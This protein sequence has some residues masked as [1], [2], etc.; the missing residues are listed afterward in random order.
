MNA[1]KLY[2]RQDIGEGNPLVLLHGMFGDGSQWSTIS[3][4]LSK[5]YR[6][7]VVDLLGHGRSPR[8]K[9]AIYTDKEHV[10]AL[11]NTLKSL[12][13]TK[14]ATVVGYSM[15]G[16][17]ALAYSSSYPESVIQL[18]LISTPF[19][20]K[21]E[22]MISNKYAGSIMFTKISTGVLGAI[23]KVMRPDSVGGRFADIGNKSAK[24]HAMIGAN[25]NVLDADIIRLNIQNLVTEFDFIG[26]LK[27]LQ[28]PLTFFA[29]KKDVFVVQPQ[30]NALRQFQPYMD[31]QRLEVIKIDHM[32]VQNLP[33]EISGL[34]KKNLVNALHIE[35]DEGK[36]PPLLL[37]HGIEGSSTYWRH[38]IKPLS[39]H[40]RVITVDLLG[41]GKSPKPL[42]IS[43][44]LSDQVRFL[45]S[46]IEK[47]GLKKFDI[48]A[49]SLGALVALAYAAKHPE[50]VKSLT[51]LAPV[52]VTDDADS[53]N[54]IIKRLHLVDQIS[55]GSYLYS[56]TAQALGYKR[57]SKYLPSL[58]TL[59]NAIRNQKA[60]DLAKKAKNIPIR[61]IYGQ[62]DGLIDKIYLEKV[63]N[64]FKKAEIIE[65]QKQGHNFALSKPEETLE[66]MFPGKTYVSKPGKLPVIPPT[67]AKHLVALAIPVLTLKSL[68]YIATGILLFTKFAPV[69]VTFGAAGYFF[70]LGFGYIQGAFSLKNER[71]SYFW[72]ILLGLAIITFGIF[73]FRNPQYALNISTFVICGLVLLAGISRVIVG[74]FWTTKKYLKNSLL[75]T[76]SLMVVAGTLA[77]AG[78]I[79]SIKLIVY[80]IAVLLIARGAQFAA[81]AIMAI[82][83]AYVRGFNR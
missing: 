50:Q 73:V 72:Y 18:Y 45:E 81:Y 67:F 13:A 35:V 65:F 27:K 51:L 40:N 79:I 39:E 17:V 20:L 1:A 71:F 47:L 14:N 26:H 41:F 22:E 53:T 56:S 23:Q 70:Y 32:L 46:T 24:F 38:L 2:V 8:P 66:Y 63:I 36:G 74:L 59:N 34:I 57:M 52:F 5:N 6:V 80:T 78:G 49:H 42:N 55:D 37:I 58:R 9:K 83:F 11:R 60:V 77:L 3:K 29:G 16:A 69:I 54:Q 30:L 62:K 44:S 31:I 25:D 7:I 19:Y 82:M 48:A 10:E 21:P 15:G 68:L 61:V 75:F 28:D 12:K 4:I 43:Y 76:G 33:R 64:L